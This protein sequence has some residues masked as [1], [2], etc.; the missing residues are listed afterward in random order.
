[1]STTVEDYPRTFLPE[2]LDPGS[3]ESVQPWVEKLLARLWHD[4]AVITGIHHQHPCV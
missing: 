3:W 1:M 4:D 2:D